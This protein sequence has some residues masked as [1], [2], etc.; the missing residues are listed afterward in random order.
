MADVGRPTIFTPELLQ[1][2]EEGFLMGYTDTEAC[3]YAGIA[4]SSLYNYQNEHKEFLE[5]K[6]Q[7]KENPRMIAKT[8]VYNRL[9]RDPE[10]AKWYLERKAKDEFSTRNEL[11]GKDGKDL[12][13]PLLAG[14]TDVH[15]N[16]STEKTDKAE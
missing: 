10:T 12:P 9:S 14:V 15:S 7:L 11:T 2:L 5:R 16:N 3:L 13:T 1:K 4:P 8:T 6:E